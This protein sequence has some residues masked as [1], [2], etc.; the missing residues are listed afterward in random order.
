M[1]LSKITALTL[2]LLLIFTF[3]SHAQ[4]DCDDIVASQDHLLQVTQTS[5]LPGD[6]VWLPVYMN[7]VNPGLM[8]F[9]Y[10]N[11]DHDYLTP[12]SD[13]VYPE[14]ILSEKTGR[15]IDA[16]G[17]ATY[18][19]YYPIDSG[20]VVAFFNPLLNPYEIPP[21]E[22]IIFR[23]AFIMNK[24]FPYGDSTKIWFQQSQETYQCRKSILAVSDPEEIDGIGTIYPTTPDSYLYYDTSFQDLPIIYDFHAQPRS[25]VAG[26]TSWLYWN[27]SVFSDSASINN[28]IGFLPMPWGIEEVTP[29]VTTTYELSVFNSFGYSKETVTIN[30]TQPGENQYPRLVN[31]NDHQ[32]IGG[33]TLSFSIW[34]NDPDGTN[35]NLSTS[36]LPGSATFTDNGLGFGNF[37]W[38]PGESDIGVH[39]ITFFATDASDPNMIDSLHSV[40]TVLDMNLPPQWDFD[41]SVYD[42]LFENDTAQFL[43]EVWDPDS[44]IPHIEGHLTGRDTLATNMTFVDSGNGKGVLTFIPDSFQGNHDPTVFYVRFTIYDSE[45][46]NISLE[47]SSKRFYVFNKNSGLEAPTLSIPDNTGSFELLGGDILEIGLYAFNTN[48]DLPTITSTALPENA[49]LIDK[50]DSVDSDYKIFKYMPLPPT[51]TNF[52]IT[53]FATTEGLV[54]SETVHI[55]VTEA[56]NIPWYFID[57]FQQDEV[58]EGSTLQNVIYVFDE[59]STI[60]IIN[61]YL[62]GQ[63]TLATN[64][65]FVDSGNG[66]GVLTF[67]PNQIQGDSPVPTFYYYRF[68]VQDSEYP[69]V[70]LQSLTNTIRVHDSG[71]PCCLGIKGDVDYNGNGVSGPNVVDVVLLVNYVVKGQGTIPCYG[72]AD[73]DN[74]G[75]LTMTDIIILV[76]YLFLNGAIPNCQ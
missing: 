57:P 53:F 27:F 52:D 38:T 17:F 14:N 43:I 22:G 47:T 15:F 54:D 11:Y 33:N 41:Y 32:V 37:S 58:V 72:E 9:F 24:F 29:D 25:I 20:C 63:D 46:L 36:P 31:V 7:N 51:D 28:G 5:G 42:T 13:P 34:A 66:Y 23:I 1:S 67:T 62:D 61:A 73:V 76:E 19:S 59:D 16:P 35:P 45:N 4:I 12:V 74:S 71:Q 75:T 30:V 65:S 50:P 64:M 26:E 6:T 10:I 18:P 60:P 2:S 48:G 70:I 69:D 56:N 49:S 40:I 68:S 3:T 44:T 55:S 21:G 39:H 8:F